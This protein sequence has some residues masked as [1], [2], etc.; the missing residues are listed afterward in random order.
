MQVTTSGNGPDLVLLPGWGMTAQVWTEVAALLSPQWRVHCVDWSADTGGAPV[1]LDALAEA[2]AALTVPR[3][4]VCGWSLGGHLALHW[5]R[6]KPAQVA[7]FILISTT[8]CFVRSAGWDHGMEPA[9]FDAFAQ[10]LAHDVAGTLQRFI[11]LQAHGDTAERTVIRRLRDCVALPDA[12]ALA[13]GL[14]LLKHTDLRADL[15]QIGQPA[16]ILHGER[17]SVV[18]AGAGDYLQ[19]TLPNARLATIAGAAHAPFIAQP[20]TVAQRIAE[21]CHG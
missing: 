2:V 13:A 12:A 18:P 9:V 6:R 19:R 17:D 20:H 3:A 21:F 7:R 10:N 11:V 5:A 4:T 8:P 14:Q 1:T 16:L 15:A